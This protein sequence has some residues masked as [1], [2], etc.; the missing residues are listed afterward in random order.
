MLISE[1]MRVP[2]CHGYLKI[3]NR[4]HSFL[5]YFKFK[6]SVYY[7][8]VQP[9]SHRLTTV[10]AEFLAHFERLW[11]DPYLSSLPQV[12]VSVP[13]APLQLW[14]SWPILNPRLNSTVTVSTTPLLWTL[15]GGTCRIQ[16]H[17]LWSRLSIRLSL[18]STL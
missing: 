5:C 1:V 13:I 14:S 4:N 9:A 12:Q 11:P 3:K 6:Y 8:R 15:F 7:G 16:T 18:R 2:S 10:T 17:N